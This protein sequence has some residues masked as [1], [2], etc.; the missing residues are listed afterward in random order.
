MGEIN[1]S[2]AYLRLFYQISI[3]YPGPTAITRL[4][5]WSTKPIVC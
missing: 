3:S 1:L 2:T 4:L 5:V